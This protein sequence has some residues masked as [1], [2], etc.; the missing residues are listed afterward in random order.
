M[1]FDND[2][3]HLTVRTHVDAAE[4]TR[5]V[6]FRDVK[7]DTQPISFWEPL[8]VGSN[9]I[10]IEFSGKILDNSITFTRKVGE[11]SDET[12]VAK[13]ADVAEEK[14]ETTPAEAAPPTATN[15]VQPS[16]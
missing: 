6:E 11:F 12:V 13:R 5:E 8:D 10:R 4:R 3:K 2:G 9:E 14:A 15:N 1:T 16:Q 7:R